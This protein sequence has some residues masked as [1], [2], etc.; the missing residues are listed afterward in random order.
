MPRF[1]LAAVACACAALAVGACGD[2]NESQSGRDAG[3]NG[4]TAATSPTPEAQTSTQSEEEQADDIVSVSIKDIKFIPHDVTVKAGQKIVWTHDDGQIP[5]NVT[6]T[7]GEK[8][9]SDTLT[10]GETYE[11]TPKK[12]GTID[13]VCTIHEGQ[14]GQITVTE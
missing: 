9:A 3:E 4:A 7:K 8:F 10:G 12:A 6:A 2:D 13:Y 1:T 11:Y 14:D 5:H